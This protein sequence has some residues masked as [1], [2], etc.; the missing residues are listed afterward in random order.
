MRNDEA[1]YAVEVLFDRGN[2]TYKPEETVT[3]SIVLHHKSQNSFRVDVACL[4]IRPRGKMSLTNRQNNKRI[5][6]AMK[7]VKEISFLDVEP[8]ELAKNKTL[9]LSHYKGLKQAAPPSGSSSPRESI[10]TLRLTWES[11]C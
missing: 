3:G 8:I 1:N 5:E 2:A 6:D 9:Y 7:V 10:S 4:L 11:T